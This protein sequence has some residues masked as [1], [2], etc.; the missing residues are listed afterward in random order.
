M[1]IIENSSKTCWPSPSQWHGCPVQSLNVL[2]LDPKF[3]IL[4]VTSWQLS[5]TLSNIRHQHRYDQFYW[6]RKI[7]E[8]IRNQKNKIKYLFSC[9]LVWAQFSSEHLYSD[10][11]PIL[12]SVER[13]GIFRT[14]AKVHERHLRRDQDLLAR[15]RLEKGT[16][17]SVSEWVLRQ[18]IFLSSSILVSNEIVFEDTG[19]MRSNKVK[20]DETYQFKTSN[21]FTP[22]KWFR[23]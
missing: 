15:F 3:T 6:S 4:V 10:N 14:L 7:R 9:R 8:F 20:L 21:K 22:V 23:E 2:I 13:P 16:N 5:P 1:L 17:T 12:I 18:T 19:Q 11:L